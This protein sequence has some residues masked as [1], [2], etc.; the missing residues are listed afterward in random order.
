MTPY[1][2]RVQLASTLI[3]QELATGVEHGANHGAVA[4]RIIEA[5]TRSYLIDL[6]VPIASTSAPVEAP[7][8]SL[9]AMLGYIGE[10]RRD[11]ALMARAVEPKHSL[12]RERL[13]EIEMK[14]SMW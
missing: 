3:C 7:V 8:A 14:G 12:Y 4:D 6:R 9:I 2:Q 1:E 10:L 5:L 13:A 11:L